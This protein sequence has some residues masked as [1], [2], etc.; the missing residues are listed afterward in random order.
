M[1]DGRH[2]MLAG[3][4]A[5]MFAREID[6]PECSS[7][8]LIVDREKKRWESKHGTVGSVALDSKGELAVAT[9]TGG[10][11]DKLRSQLAV[12][13]LNDCVKEIE[14][15]RIQHAHYPASLSEVD[16]KDT[17]QFAKCF[18]PTVLDLFN[19]NRDRHF[20]YQLYP[21]GSFYLLRSVGP[22]GV[23]FTGDDIVPT[24]SEDERVKIG[25]R[26]QK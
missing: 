13:M 23:P 8:T 20:F 12:T 15:Y 16:P 26:L 4:G 10:I 19:S 6:F 21:S 24:I 7:E 11:F 5:L 22:D 1:N 14:F 9:S 3:E 18:D 25:L 2:L 17:T